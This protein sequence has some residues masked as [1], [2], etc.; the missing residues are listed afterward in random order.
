MR[1]AWMASSRV[2]ITIP[3]SLVSVS[4][5]SVSLCVL[6]EFECSPELFVWPCCESIAP[7]SGTAD[8][9][10]LPH[11]VWPERLQSTRQSSC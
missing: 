1:Q 10:V 4:R 5:F 6:G 7:S 11:T 3:P 2:V 9:E 8:R